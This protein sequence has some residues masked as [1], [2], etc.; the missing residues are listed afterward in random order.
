MLVEKLLR[1]CNGIK[2]IYLLLRSKRGVEPRARF[3]ELLDAKVYITLQKVLFINSIFILIRFLKKFIK[4]I[5]N[6]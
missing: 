3:E 1:S 6:Y 2:N 5:Q 4:K